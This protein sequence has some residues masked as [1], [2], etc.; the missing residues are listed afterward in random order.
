MGLKFLEEG[1]E[2]TSHEPE[3]ATEMKSLVFAIATAMCLASTPAH[4][5]AE[6][7]G[8]QR[9]AY[10]GIKIKFGA[11][12]VQKSLLVSTV[13]PRVSS[14]PFST[15]LASFIPFDKVSDL[16]PWNWSRVTQVGF[17]VVTVLG[18][19][20]V[21]NHNRTSSRRYYGAFTT[22]DDLLGDED[23]LPGNEE[24]TGN[25]DHCTDGHGQDG[26]Q[27]PHCL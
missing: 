8:A 21:I 15:R 7:T 14:A 24:E 12:K 9:G 2:E 1:S 5:G 19:G 4:A 26:E 20:A 11:G 18:V 13:L 3:G 23:D 17:G 22:D 25:H 6:F 10:I 16:Y 27:N